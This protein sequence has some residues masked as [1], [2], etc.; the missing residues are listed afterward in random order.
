MFHLFNLPKM[1][2]PE[3]IQSPEEL[4]IKTAKF[5][6]SIQVTPTPAINLQQ[7]KLLAHLLK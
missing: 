7:Q 6:L 3:N 1:M 4:A 5:Q 2:I